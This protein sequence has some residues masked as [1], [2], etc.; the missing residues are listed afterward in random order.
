MNV[1]TRKFAVVA[2][3]LLPAMAWGAEP[4]PQ[5]MSLEARAALVEAAPKGAAFRSAGQTYQMVGGL[6]ATPLAPGSTVDQGLAAARSAPTE[7]VEV[8]GP[9]LVFRESA[10]RAPALVPAAAVVDQARTFPV[11]VNTRTGRLGVAANVLVVKLADVAAAPALAA[12]NGLELDFVADRI[13]YAFFRV[14]DGR[15][16]LGA[17]ATMSRD[18]RVTSAEIEVREHFATP[19]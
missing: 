14:P 5:G 3:A 12:A 6:R 1:S 13:G 7:L 8:K 2:L 19:R 9:Y 17:A 10:T 11:V 4:A 15:D 16:L 18:G